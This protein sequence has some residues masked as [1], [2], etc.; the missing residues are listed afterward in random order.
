MSNKKK[1]HHKKILTIKNRMLFYTF[2]IIAFMTVLSVYSLTITNVYKARIDG[3]FAR[4]IM[5][6][7]IT[8]QLVI[9][10]KELVVYLSTKSSTSLNNYMLNAEKLKNISQEL[11]DRVEYY[12]EEDLMVID[13]DNMIHNYI[14]EGGEAVQEKRKSNVAAYTEKLETV[15]TIKGYI[16]SYVNELNTRQLDRNSIHYVYMSQQIKVASTLNIVLILDI[17]LLAF[18][19]VFKMSR[20]MIDPI[21]RLSHSVGE[22]AMGQFDTEEIIVETKDELEILARAFNKMKY[23]IRVY[24]EELKEKAFM[25][26]SLK[27]QQMENLKMQSL[28]D[29]ARLYA[30]QSQM[31]PHFLFNTI[32]AGVQLSMIEGADRTSEFLESMSRLFRY[33]INQLDKIQAVTV[34]QEVDNIRDYYELIKVRFGE[35]IT[36][37]FVID[38]A[39]TSYLM[40]PLILQPL[41]ENAYMHGLSKKEEGGWINIQVLNKVSEIIVVVEDNGIGISQEQIDGIFNENSQEVALIKDYSNGIGLKN[42]IERLELFYKRKN[43]IVIQSHLNQGTKII[44]TLPHIKGESND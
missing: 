7:E 31:N 6:K 32:N 16:I 8:D 9:V 41:V 10:D 1:V 44:C 18:S 11:I 20:S 36:F 27:D 15:S 14:I 4:N 22:V 26:A 39:G 3:M 29:N 35:L 25:E 12:T 23:S 40:P 34:G 30:L 37:K 2:G 43:L 5:L 42:V 13:I 21:V 19:I 38:E 17:I 33:N 24:I 28:L